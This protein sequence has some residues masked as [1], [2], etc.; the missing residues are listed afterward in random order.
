[1][2][3]EPEFGSWKAVARYASTPTPKHPARLRR[4]RPRPDDAVAATERGPRPR[5][6]FG[7]TT[8]RHERAVGHP[9][10]GQH[11]HGAEVQGETRTA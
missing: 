5:G 9:D 3:R 6:V 2:W 1:M 10:R 4:V 7:P 11:E 8:L